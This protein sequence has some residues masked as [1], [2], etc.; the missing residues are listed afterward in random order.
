VPNPSESASFI[1]ASQSPQR[2]KL[3]RDAGFE[4]TCE[5]AD[6]DEDSFAAKTMPMDLALDLALA[7]AN[8]IADKHPDRVILG[9]DTVVAFG[10]HVI[11]KPLD[12]AHAR[13]ILQLISGT[14]VVV[15]TGI[16][17]AHGAKSWMKTARVMS[18]ARI[19]SLTHH[20]LEKYMLSGAWR[21]KAGGFGVQDENTIVR[22]V[23]G[24]RTN[25]IGLPMKT[26]SKLLKDAGILTR[27]P[28][29]G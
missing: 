24:C 18:A 27:R 11:G 4:F 9:A 28:N 10:D 19:K 23:V 25:V 12:A 22:D 3:L 17:V 8:F 20:E 7:K 1:L 21:N 5:P 14:T 13:E 15:I 6:I 26:A 29:G 2:Q 16:A